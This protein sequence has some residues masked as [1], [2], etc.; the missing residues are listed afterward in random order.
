VISALTQAPNAKYSSFFCCEL[1]LMS[2]CTKSKKL[3]ALNSAPNFNHK[4]I[5]EFLKNKKRGWLVE[6]A[7]IFLPVCGTSTH[8]SSSLPTG[9]KKRHDCYAIQP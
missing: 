2:I 7:L 1:P 5:K 6:Q 3:E 4:N 8:I 9:H